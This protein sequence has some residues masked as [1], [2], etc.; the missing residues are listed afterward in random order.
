MFLQV[1]IGLQEEDINMKDTVVEIH[2]LTG[3]EVIRHL[4]RRPSGV[5]TN[6]DPTSTPIA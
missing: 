5:Q 2:P 6:V 1:E 4:G 3:E